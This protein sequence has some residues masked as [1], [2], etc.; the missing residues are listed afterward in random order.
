MIC[1]I[2]TEFGLHSKDAELS[3][4]LVRKALGDYVCGP[5]YSGGFHPKTGG[6][7]YVDT[8]CHPE[9]ATPECSSAREAVLHIK[10][11]VKILQNSLES[12]AKE[13]S[14]KLFMNNTAYDQVTTYGSH[15]N[16]MISTPLFNE[17][18]YSAASGKRRT[19]L[20]F[21]MTR[22]IITGAGY[23]SINTFNESLIFRISQ[24][25]SFIGCVMGGNSTN[26]RPIIHTRDESHCLKAR[27]SRLHLIVGDSNMSEF[28]TWL[29]I[30]TTMII[31]HLLDLKVG[32]EKAVPFFY[33]DLISDNILDKISLDFSLQE[34]FNTNWGEMSALVVQ[35]QFLKFAQKYITP[36]M[37]EMWHIVKA[38]KFTLDALE[39][40]KW[41]LVGYLDWI[42]KF[43]FS[44]KYAKKELNINMPDMRSR[45]F[46]KLRN[47][48]MRDLEKIRGFCLGYHD[49]SDKGIFAILTQSGHMKRL[50]TNSQIKEAMG[51]SPK[52]RARWRTI[53][54]KILQSKNIEYTAD[55][56]VVDII[57]PKTRKTE[58]KFVNGD[59][60]NCYNKIDFEVAKIL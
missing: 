10:A 6:R 9:Y 32:M 7:V 55:W 14:E 60:Y 30:G 54:M 2:E 25:S 15:E 1:G 46:L 45:V 4:K 17:I 13:K 19:L 50:F 49:I 37:G 38:W 12:I 33:G 47:G 5:A 3:V 36:Q 29:K 16:Y 22:Q 52:T 59:P 20:A 57:Q 28:A 40:D 8:G 51:N 26:A 44:A 18:V 39:N 53:L 43:Y 23:W 48:N 35:K 11:G 42:T 27:Y 58:C 34:K 24:R 21:L 56:S 31:L 41:A